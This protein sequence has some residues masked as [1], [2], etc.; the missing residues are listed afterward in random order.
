MSKNYI[1]FT[2]T[3]QKGSSTDI[4]TQ[5]SVSSDNTTDGQDDDNK[6]HH[7]SSDLEKKR[8]DTDNLLK[9]IDEELIKRKVHGIRSC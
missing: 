2:S 1:F 9:G 6:L 7:V 3:L 4:K 8:L 5:I